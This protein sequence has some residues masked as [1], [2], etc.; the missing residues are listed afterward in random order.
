[1]A[2][3][4]ELA[5][6]ATPESRG[7]DQSLV[8][9]ATRTFVGF[10]R[11]GS[12]LAR[13]ERPEAFR[14]FVN[15]AR[16]PLDGVTADSWHSVS[17]ADATVNGDNYLQVCCLAEGCGTLELRVPYPTLRDDTAAWAG[18]PSLELLDQIIEAEVEAGFSCAQLVVVKDGAVI[19]RGHYGAVSSYEQDGTPIPAARRTPVTDETL[20]DM[21]SNTKMFACNMALQK[22]ASE[23][24]VD[25]GAR[26]RD[27]LPQFR[28]LPGAEIPG[29]D[30]LTISELL[31]H[32]AGF[33]ADPSYHNADYD[34]ALHRVVAGSNANATLFT[35][36]RDEALEKIVATPLEYAPGTATRYSDVDYMLLGFIV[37]AIVG[38]RLDDYLKQEVYGPL[39]LARTTYQPLRHGF[40]KDDCAATE[41]N[42][43]TRDGAVSFANVRRETV[44]GQCHDAKAF[45]VMGEVSGHAGLFSSASDIAVLEQ[46]VLNRGGYGDVRL[47]DEDTLDRFIKPKDTDP[48][49]GLGWRRKAHDGYTAVFSQV[50]DTATIGH[51]GWTGT[52]TLIDPANHLG[53]ALLT[54][55]RNTPVL[56][57][58]KD[59]NDF[60]G[61]HFLIG[62]YAIAPTL[63]YQA[64]HT[65][66]EAAD[67]LLADV[68]RA[69]RAEVAAGGDFDTAPDRADLAALESVA[70]KRGVRL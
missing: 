10:E 16:V 47:F 63:V 22:L 25:L 35:Q 24:K 12:L 9:N 58:A 60:V 43:N 5:C 36:S 31:Q 29:K 44:Q 53:I 69:K 3:Q 27:Y 1:M 55:R 42:G 45:H 68:V 64:L 14:V 49:Y 30:E 41:L 62:R 19:K 39:G 59:P 54:S 46:V 57:P 11:Q 37:E 34:P 15:G 48:S 28:D 6:P 52:F 33:P 32:Q 38:M 40:S 23:G 8:T 50:P 65:S 18:N 21:A 4:L 20:F 56:D 70:R 61:C 17:I 66:A 26:V 2:C 51:T 67:A 7:Y 13:C